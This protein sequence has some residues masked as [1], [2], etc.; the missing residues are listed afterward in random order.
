MTSTNSALRRS[1]ARGFALGDDVVRFKT[2][3]KQRLKPQTLVNTP[4]FSSRP[5]CVPRLLP[6]APV[7][8][9]PFFPQRGQSGSAISSL[10]RLSATS[11]S[12]N[13]CATPG[14]EVSRSSVRA[15]DAR[16]PKP[17]AEAAIRRG[18]ALDADTDEGR[19]KMKDLAELPPAPARRPGLEHRKHYRSRREFNASRSRRAR[20]SAA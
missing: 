8:S 5:V 11:C 19:E 17:V 2:R 12:C 18:L 6:F 16:V 14:G 15:W 1:F 10:D 9:L 7:R 4:S 20:Q 13:P 3:D